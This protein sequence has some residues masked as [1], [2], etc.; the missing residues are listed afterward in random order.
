M[1][2]H[3]AEMF[4]QLISKF[5]CTVCFRCLLSK[6]Q[7]QDIISWKS[8]VVFAKWFLLLCKIN[9]F[10][11]PFVVFI[12]IVWGQCFWLLFLAKEKSV[13][14]VCR[15]FFWMEMS[16]DVSFFCVKSGLSFLFREF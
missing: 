9:L 7:L 11:K 16:K 3:F 5:I 8:I 10:V 15:I 4:F 6:I 12:C 14:F 1:S 2:Q 13:S